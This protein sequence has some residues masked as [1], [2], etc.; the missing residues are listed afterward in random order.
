MKSV[1]GRNHKRPQDFW[2]KKMTR[3]VYYLH[4]KEKEYRLKGKF[5]LVGMGCDVTVQFGK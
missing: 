3:C 5:F 1:K 4:T 2:L